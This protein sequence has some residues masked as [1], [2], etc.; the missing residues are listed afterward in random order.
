[1]RNSN[2]HRE[3]AA[4]R[5]ALVA[6]HDYDVAVDLS[7]APD[8]AR[9]GFATT[10]TIRFAAA[11]PGAT[12]FLD[13]IGLGVQSVVLNGKELDPAVV[14]EDARIALPDLAAE[15]TVVV[16]ATAAY[17][18]SGEGLHRFT[19]PA[20]GRV[21]TYTQYEPADARR[22][23]ANFE[24]PDLKAPFTFHVTAPAGWEV[25]S[26][27]EPVAQ[28]PVGTANG[29]AVRW[30]FAPTAPIST[31]IT[32]ILA[33]PYFKAED[34]FAMTFGPDSAHAGEILEI[35][36]AAYCRASMAEHFDAGAIFDVTK[37]G[38][39]FFHRVF[40]YP[41]PFGKY[42]QAFVPEYNLGAMENPGLVTFTEAYVFTSR[43]TDTQY[44]QRANT[45][46]HE[47]A[48][49]WFGDLVTM[50]WWDDLWLKESFAD[51]MG[52]LAVAE[53]TPWAA[54]SWTL[55][56]S[57]RKTWAYVQDQLPTT[58]PIVADI[59]TLEAA[60]QNFDGIT[61]AKGASVLKQL[62]A[63]VG[64]DAFLAGAREY[65][66]THAYANTALA[67]LLEPLGTASGRDLRT[68]AR[69]WLQTAG[70]ATLTPAVTVADGAITDLSIRQDAVDPVTG[71]PAPRPHRLAVGLYRFDGDRNDGG[72]L[73]RYGRA[74]IDVAGPVT[75]VTELV[76]AP[77]PD[78]VIVNDEDLTYAKV[79]LDPA[80]LATA[81][82]GLDALADPMARSLVW[83]SLWNA[84]RDA[85]LSAD[86]YVHAVA[87][88]AASE[89]DI[90]VL[91]SLVDNAC[92]ALTH[93]TPA[94]TRGQLR[95]FLA[96]AVE[97]ELDAAAAGSDQQLVWARALA[98]L[99]R[100]SAAVA[101]RLRALLGGSG[102]PAGLAMDAD[103]RWRA[104]QGLAAQGVATEAELDAALA[105]DTTAAT[106]ADHATA[107]AARPSADVKEA[108]WTS[109][110][111]DT[112]LTNQLLGATI[113]GFT[114]G[115]PEL[116]A[117]F[118]DRYFAAIDTVWGQRSIEIADRIV[119]GLYPGRQDLPP[120]TDP[121]AHPTVRRT[122]AWLAA[123]GD[124]APGL[125]RI[126][127]ERRDHLLWALAGQAF[128]REPARGEAR[129]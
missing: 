84:T 50:A 99:G 62:V 117:P 122:D 82:T 118:E 12:T 89:D 114:I 19:D 13:F 17:S 39:A 93:Y 113:S 32:T 18:R 64:Q 35:P 2:L 37:A 74:T 80:S 44:Q 24:Q 96:T 104:W 67:D 95:A 98:L 91:Q 8:A 70:I 59:P 66:R 61:Y 51:F 45:I 15:N 46:M 73:V 126:I 54:K 47:M 123:H 11:T 6:V 60:K 110:L 48:H 90:A 57:R 109:A 30:D 10:S 38:L 25:G 124:A 31:Y 101:P 28:T 5:K 14:V 112:T 78:L 1:M 115:G 36:L 128:G 103:L 55:F 86:A 76:G 129:P 22:V 94:E 108:A 40:D 97:R 107:L 16:T 105:A 72:A 23:F 87:A 71:E 58:H 4:A 56:A 92:V 116:L 21:Y 33:G 53:A 34:H 102:V 43:A 3:E 42:G 20:D 127:V 106:R 120:G 68:W 65:F 111:G 29:D 7:D 26:N 75:T 77:A 69:Q 100:D 49:M 121:A 119:A 85:V 88:F 63:Y 52:H 27:R 81:L 125:R 9:P 41:Y 79:R 83:S